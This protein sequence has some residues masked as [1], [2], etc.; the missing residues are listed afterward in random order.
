[1]FQ[2]YQKNLHQPDVFAVHTIKNKQELRNY[3]FKVKVVNNGRQRI[4]R[5]LFIIP[6]RE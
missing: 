5:P 4:C 3:N 6:F 1:M 2:N